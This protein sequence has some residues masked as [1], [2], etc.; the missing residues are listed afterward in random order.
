MQIEETL[1]DVETIDNACSSRVARAPAA[2]YCCLNRPKCMSRKLLLT[3]YIRCRLRRC[4]ISIGAIDWARR[5]I[6]D[7]LSR[8]RGYAYPQFWGYRTTPPHFSGVQQI[9]CSDFPSAYILG[10]TVVRNLD[11]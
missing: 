10:L 8:L 11:F 1:I 2:L 5:F 3:A 7:E 4:K 9:N 6:V